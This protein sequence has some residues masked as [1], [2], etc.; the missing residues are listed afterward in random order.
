MHTVTSRAGRRSPR[1]MS[2]AAARFVSLV[3]REKNAIVERILIVEDDRADRIALVRTLRKLERGPASFDLEIVEAGTL[4]EA[5]RAL[6]DGNWR[7]IICDHRLPDG[8]GG[9]LLELAREHDP[10]VAFIVLTGQGDESLAA[11]LMKR[12]A[13]DYIPKGGLTPDRLRTSMR[14]AAALADAEQIADKAAAGHRFL[15]EAG[16][17]LVGAIELGDVIEAATRT[18]V[19]G[20]A[21]FCLLDLEIDAGDFRRV[22]FAHSDPERDAAYREPVLAAAEN[23]DLASAFTDGG[24]G[25]PVAVDDDWLRRMGGGRSDGPL[26]ELCPGYA[27]TAPLRARGRVLGY[28]TFLRE[29]AQPFG[30]V[31]RPILRRYANKVALA[32]DNARLYGELQESIGAR[33]RILAVVAHD[34]RNPLSAITGAA[35][36]L[37]AMELPAPAKRRQIEL[38][39]SAADRMTRLVEDLLDVAHLE[40]GALSVSPERQEAADVVE[41]AVSI[42]ASKTEERG[43]TIDVDMPPDCPPLHVDPGRGSQIL[44]NLL[45]NAIRFT[46]EGGTVKVRV[47]PEGSGLV[48]FEVLDQGPGIPEEE[49]PLLFRRFWQSPSRP[50]RGRAGLGLSIARGLV[51]LHGG[52]IGA[53]SVAEGGTRFWFTLPVHPPSG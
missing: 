11:E 21:D 25:E 50:R 49:L 6:E 26:R 12:G 4:A 5:S 19:K 29:E 32:L 23:A 8:D 16:E 28:L 27:L 20:W 47:A 53:E 13:R 46:P 2:G 43:I 9:D 30:D 40:E 41:G 45:D 33:E 1:K 52:A 39:G 10:Y 34:L 35:Y 48:R 51:E 44:S 17:S 7:W 38:I 22:G 42:L 24:E 18:C 14:A 3:A 36:N 31:E 15:A 37:L